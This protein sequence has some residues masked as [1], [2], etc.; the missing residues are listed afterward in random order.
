MP[1]DP[2][3]SKPTQKNPET[4]GFCCVGFFCFLAASFPT[5]E[6]RDVDA[7]RAGS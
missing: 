5:K 4:S 3:K 2:L 7:E 6:T 1:G